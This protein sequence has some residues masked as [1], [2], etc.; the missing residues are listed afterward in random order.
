MQKLF[1]S[2]LCVD[3]DQWPAFLASRC[4]TD[5]E[6]AAEIYQLLVADHSANHFLSSEPLLSDPVNESFG[7]EEK[8]AAPFRSLRTLRVAVL[9]R[10]RRH[11]AGV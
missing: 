5:D 7:T 2:A 6:L 8:A 4:G 9:P 10:R 3:Q 11:G 1:E